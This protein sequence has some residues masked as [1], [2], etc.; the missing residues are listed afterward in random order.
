VSNRSGVVMRFRALS[1]IFGL[2]VCNWAQTPFEIGRNVVFQVSISNDQRDFHVGETIPLRLAFSSSIEN[3]YQVNRA[4][5]DRSGRMELEHFHLTPA[6]AT[7]D[8]LQ[9]H[10]GGGGGGLTSFSFLGA[11]PWTIT[12]NLNEWVRFTRP[13]NY[14]LIVTSNR[15]SVKDLSNPLG[16]SPITVESNEITLRILPATKAWQEATQSGAVAIL[17]PTSPSEPQN[18]ER[19]I[20][21]RRQALE[22]LRFLG[23]AEAANELAKRLRGEDADGLDYVCM[24]GLISSPE[25]ETV[26]SA[27]EKELA[28]PDHPISQTFISTLRTVNADPTDHDLRGTQR[29]AVEELLTVLPAKRGKALTVSLSTAANEAWNS[30]D[31]PK[32]TT[33]RLI[34]QMISMFDQLPVDAQSLFLIYRWDKIAGPQMLPILR[35]VAEVYHD[36]PEMREANA[37]QSLELSASALQH[38]YELDPAGARPAII[39]EITRP[40]PR[41]GAKVLG[42]LPDKTLP[43]VEFPLAEHLSASSDFEGLANI[44]SLIARYATDAILAPVTTKLDPLVGKWACAIQN[45]LLAYVLRVDPA[46]ARVRI[47]EALAARGKE[48][49]ACN[50]ELFQ[51]ISEIHYDA[52]LEEIGIRSLDDPD[53]QVA[54]TAA[55]M[56]GNYGS[57][58]AE[59][60]LLQ[61][62]EQWSADW[63]GEEEYLNLT[64][65]EQTG[66]RIYQ[67]GLGENLAQALATGKSWLSDGRTLERLSHLTKVRRVRDR[68]DEYWKV[69]QNPPLVISLGENPPSGLDLRVAQY[70]FHSLDDLEKKLSQF[71]TGTRFVLASSPTAPSKQNRSLAEIRNFLSNH[72]RLLAGEKQTE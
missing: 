52:V 72:G 4:Q 70:E 12:L 32:Q 45:P 23:T 33:D 41:F 57:A 49:T 1:L 56:L 64:F 9:G 59:P 67:L 21:S 40:R 46:G 11:E 25:V 51:E 53:P 10:L 55:T 44:A 14:R 7:V 29:K 28:N 47:E 19:Y 69:W 65:A 35:H 31:I 5:Y 43:E 13:G 17:D 27:L 60:A 48:S 37:Y 68:L 71:P 36:Y 34:E 38:W 6:T 16:A 39:R 8:P 66:D 42:I 18:K 62:F 15:V 2:V 54:E 30:G 26:K 22:T 50:H 63:A 20:T 24:L 61:R 3:H 58:A